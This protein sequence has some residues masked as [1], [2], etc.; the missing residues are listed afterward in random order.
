MR[1]Y[2][3]QE[4]FEV[5]TQARMETS[6]GVLDSAKEVKMEV[7][8]GVSDEDKYGYFELYDLETG[9]DRFYGEGGLWFTGNKL[10]DYDG[11]FELSQH[12]IAKLKEWGYDVSE[13]E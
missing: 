1:N 8:V 9:G 12:V 5:T 6:Y 2:N 3:K 13:V 10:T 11:V 7:T 4:T